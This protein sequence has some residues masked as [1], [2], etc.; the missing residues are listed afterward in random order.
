MRICRLLIAS[1]LLG[2]SQPTSYG[3]VGDQAP[4]YAA[5]TPA[6]NSISLNELRG[7]VVLLNIWATWCIPCR[8]ELPELQQLHQR[9]SQQ[10][11][12]VVGVSVDD[13]SADR[14]VDEFVRNFGLTYTILRDPAE[15]VSHKFA[16]PGVPASFLIDRNGKVVWRMTGP[17]TAGDTILQNALR[18]SL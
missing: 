8:K 3:Y 4:E 14:A 13:G 18:A 6:G 5:P 10:G 17:F 9:Y 7:S 1:L 12:R 11:L 2:C 16:I 15:T